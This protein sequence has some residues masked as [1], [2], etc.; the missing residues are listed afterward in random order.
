MSLVVCVIFLFLF[1]GMHVRSSVNERDLLAQAS[2]LTLSSIGRAPNC[3]VYHWSQ[4]IQKTLSLN[5]T[6]GAQ[7]GI[8]LFSGG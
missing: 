2:R 5:I 8:S 3:C 4:E 7:R 1:L 6:F